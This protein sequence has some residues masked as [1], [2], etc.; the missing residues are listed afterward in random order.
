[1]S[2]RAFLNNNPAVMTIGT[3]VVLLICLAVIYN[4]LRGNGGRSPANVDAYF[5]DEGTG[6]IFTASA[7]EYAP[8]DAPSGPGAGVRA[9][10]YGCGSC[11]PDTW[12]IAYLEKYGPEAHHALV[13]DP[14]SEAAM[15]AESDGTLVRSVD[16]P[17]WV[18]QLTRIGLDLMD[19]AAQIC[20][21]GGLVRCRP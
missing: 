3:I 15:M 12:T 14:S 7:R 8:I 9:V 16:N 4:N 19:R 20:P 13:N 6:E 18:P 5:Y 10:I 2:V 11:D 1:M 21:D 17:Q